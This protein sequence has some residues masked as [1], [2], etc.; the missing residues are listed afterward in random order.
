MAGTPAVASSDRCQLIQELS[1][2][3]DPCKRLLPA[4]G[5]LP[6]GPE[7]MPTIMVHPP[8]LRK[9]DGPVQSLQDGES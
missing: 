1:P 3:L 5:L 9:A 8:S 4:V 2:P 7:P 6:S